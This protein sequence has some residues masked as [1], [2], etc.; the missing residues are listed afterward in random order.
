M[1]RVSRVA[2][3]A[4]AM[5]TVSGGLNN[6]MAAP[7]VNCAKQDAQTGI[8]LVE[9]ISPGQDADA[10]PVAGAVSPGGGEPTGGD[11]SPQNPCTYTV[12]QPQPPSTSALWQGQSPTDGAMYAKVCPRVDGSGL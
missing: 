7:P 9:A 12:A 8:C 4:A 3:L 2:L 11:A 6:A 1:L 10:E 5:L